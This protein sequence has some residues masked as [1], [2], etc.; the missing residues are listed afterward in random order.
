M[1]KELKVLAY[2]DKPMTMTEV[3]YFTDMT[4]AYWRD[5]EKNEQYA[6]PHTYLEDG[7][8][9]YAATL[10]VPDG[11]DA[12]SFVEYWLTWLTD[13]TRALLGARWS[14]ELDGMPLR[15]DETE[16]WSVVTG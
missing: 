7:G 11:E 9:I 6:G 16:G 1:A 13:I 10:D 3:A 14:V 15:W 2:R 4:Q 8:P 12:E 5:Y